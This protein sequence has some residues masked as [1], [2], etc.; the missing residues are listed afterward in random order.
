MKISVCGKGGSG[1]STIVALL[2]SEAQERGY[3]V[4][5]VDADESNSGLFRLLGFD[6][7]PLPLMEFLGGKPGLK[8]RM[9]QPSIFPEPTITV[10]GIPPGHLLK[11]NGLMLVSIG[12]ILQSLEGCACPMGVLSR[13]FLKKLTIKKGEMVIVDTEAG[14]EHFGRGVET[15]LD[16]VLIVVE[17]SLESLELATRANKLS[18]GS[19]IKN[20][21]AVL[22][23]V[24]SA[25]IT[26]QLK[27]ELARKKIE[28][29][30]RIHQDAEVLKSGL[31]GSAIKRGKAIMEIVEVLDRIL[32][33]SSI[34]S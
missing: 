16:S 2:A 18:A 25:G 6:R 26:A 15:S 9:R 14:I 31:E 27:R 13:E 12:K 11:R 17:P 29:I 32:E 5:V 3:R 21:W 23:K 19:G 28:V 1:K 20:I 22:N 33:G 10:D 7:P 24:P 8:D 34:S 30:G 4:L